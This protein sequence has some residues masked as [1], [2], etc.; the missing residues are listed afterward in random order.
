MP[1]ESNADKAYM[2]DLPKVSFRVITDDPSPAGVTS[3]QSRSYGYNDFSE[4]ERS[5]HYIRYIE[6]IESE[7]AVQVEYDMDEQDQEWLDA[8]NAER[9]KEQS[10]AIS[11]EVFEILMD[12][13]EKEWFNL[14]KK[15]PQPVQHLAAEDSKCAVCDDGEGENSNAIVFCDGCNLAVHQ[16]CYGVPY[17]PEGQWLCRKCTVSPENPVSCIFCPNEGGA[18]KQT[19]SGHWAHLL[20]AIWIP[21]TGLGNAIYMEPVEG[22]EIVPKSRW[23]LFC[24]LC[25]EKTGAC[26]QCDNRS[27]F[28][29]FH[30]TCARQV[31]LLSSMKSF[32][33]DGLLKAYCHKHLPAE[34]RDSISDTGSDFSSFSE[35]IPVKSSKSKNKARRSSTVTGQ[36]QVVVPATKKSAQAHSKSFRPGPPIIPKLVLDTVL[37]YVAKVVIR[38]KQP[39]VERL[40]RYWSLKR[41]ARRGA[42]LLKRLHLEPWTASSASR[43]Q[44]DAE[45]AQKLK[46]LQML[47]NDLEKVRMLAELVRKREKEKL[48][49]VQVIKDV[50]DSFIFPHHG[51]LRVAFE[52]ISAMD[53]QE[54]YLNPVN[55][56]EAPDYFEIIKEPMCWLWIDEK[57]EKNEYIDLSEFKRHIMLVLDNAMLYNPKDNPYHRRAAKIKKESEPIL[58]E[59]DS[60]SE[61]ARASYQSDMPSEEDTVLPIGDL[62]PISALLSTLLQQSS[63][64]ND[65]HQDHLESIFAFELEKPKEPTPPPPP[66]P[67]K[68]PR[69]SL[70][71]AERRQKWEDRENAAKERTLAGSRSTRATRAAEIAFNEEAGIQASSSAEGSKQPSVEPKEEE[72]DA[73][74]R[75]RSMREAVAIAGPSSTPASTRPDPVNK[76]QTSTS[77]SLTTSG[78]TSPTKS[79]TSLPRRHRAQIGVV[80]IETIPVLTDRERREQ[81]RKLDI[82]MEEVG[83]QDQFTRFNVGWVLP[84]G[85]KRKRAERTSDSL[86]RAP[87]IA[88]SRKP[89]STAASKARASTTPRTLRL[90]LSPIKSQPIESLQVTSGSGSDLSS[91]P[92][93]SAVTSA[94]PT[95]RRSTRQSTKGEKR[96]APVEEESDTPRQ[97]KRARTTRSNNPTDGVQQPVAEDEDEEMTPVPEGSN[98]PVDLDQT[99]E[100]EETP[101]E[102]EEVEG[103]DQAEETKEDADEK[104]GSS[105][106]KAKDKDTGK[107]KMKITSVSPKKTKQGLKRDAEQYTPGTLVWARI[108]TF[109]YF[110]AMIIDL[111]DT[112]DIPADVLAVEA[113]ERAAAKTAGRKIWLVN[114]FDAS[115]S[116]GWIMEDK[117]DLLGVDPD[118]DALYLAGK[119]RNK[120]SKHKSHAIR[121]V[122]KGYRQAMA[123]MQSEDEEDE[124]EEK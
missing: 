33:Q 120:S 14:S 42:P 92:P 61:T 115:A 99:E 24:Q 119:E 122:K 109:P 4:F 3:E 65:P 6:P 69:K 27:C 32:N 54:L 77:T 112:E 88:S 12:K 23:K 72:M 55:R 5:E 64:P 76:Q 26:I 116:Y 62:E 39:F 110:P 19:T 85:S 44:T 82:M 46:F 71:H 41:E 79:S 59:L 30:V 29:A 98:E 89:P 91:P 60:I 36:A 58:A 43:Q 56:A 53:R 51:K 34:E 57:L 17:I 35:T 9:K 50:V 100:R 18:F 83:A 48:R 21:E 28:T 47:R 107:A 67:V 13:L 37:D 75:R 80:G 104:S 94:A 11:Y 16:D 15:I 8:I 25:R 31:G 114:F 124:D 97:S 73:R 103:V 105:K 96:K 93:S 49:Q 10:G 66:K 123:S 90:S 2:H 63:G 74:S 22:V 108:H 95:P 106:A 68:A 1:L 20:C 118:L 7:L 102:V 101:E 84:E 121:M 52:K 70:S 38:K 111:A 117:L 81:E 45:K 113:K 87:S 40:C 86:P 78:S